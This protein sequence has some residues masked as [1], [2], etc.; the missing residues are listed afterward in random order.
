MHVIVTTSDVC[1]LRPNSCQWGHLLTQPTRAPLSP[2][3]GVSG[4]GQVSHPLPRQQ[5]VIQESRYAL[6]TGNKTMWAHPELVLVAS[7][8]GR[9]WSDC[10]RLQSKGNIQSSFP[11]GT[12]CISAYIGWTWESGAEDVSLLVSSGTN[13]THNEAGI[14]FYCWIS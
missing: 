6:E 5:S 2:I 10:L 14:I 1:D 7:T 9:D 3:P 13:W 8:G 4:D 11:S 12:C